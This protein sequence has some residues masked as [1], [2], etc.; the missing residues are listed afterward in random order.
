M[1]GITF[2]A[3]ILLPVICFALCCASFCV[4]NREYTRQD[5][6]QYVKERDPTLR[7]FRERV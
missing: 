3:V 1:I 5:W 4:G 2:A 7:Y 6:D